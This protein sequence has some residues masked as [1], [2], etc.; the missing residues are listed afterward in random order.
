MA[1]GSIIYVFHI[2]KPDGSGIYL[3]P[4]E[5]F[6][7][8]ISKGGSFQ[9]EGRYGE[10]PV[11]ESL[12][13]FRNTLYRIIEDAVNSWITESRFIPRFLGSAGIFLFVYFFLSFVIRDPLPML[14]EIVSG[15]AAAVI[16]YILMGRKYKN[17]GTASR[18]RSHYR[19]I[20]D[21]IIFR[22]SAFALAVES[23]LAAADGKI[24]SEMP[25]AIRSSW[26]YR[27]LVSEEYREER[28]QFVSYIERTLKKELP[29]AQKKIIN[30]IVTEG[31][32]KAR[33]LL[34]EI[35]V[36]GITGEIDISLLVIYLLLRQVNSHETV[37]E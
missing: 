17:T 10:E 29:G 33:E 28:V 18:L 13:A 34:G 27:N 4:F 16:F 12:T 9:I 21:R 24:I 5:E 3:H 30:R 36:V 37:A 14:D 7:R 31:V 11:I 19:G 25:E 1:S 26:Q 23:S 20:I 2:R 8:I 32:E 6:D 35:D 15:I 22:E